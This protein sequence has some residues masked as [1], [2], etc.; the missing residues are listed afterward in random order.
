ARQA[1]DEALTER[2]VDHSEDDRDGAGCLFQRCNNWRAMSNDQVRRRVHQLRRVSQD[3]GGIA[4]GKSIVDPDIAALRPSKCLKLW[5]KGR[6][7][8]LCLRIAFCEA[9]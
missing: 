6:G 7:T 3:T 2:I 4:A 8:S 9:L 5:A 1:C